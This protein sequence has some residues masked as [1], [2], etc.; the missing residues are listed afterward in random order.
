MNAVS[1]TC[2]ASAVSNPVMI[3]EVKVEDTISSISQGIRCLNKS[4]TEARV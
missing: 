4:Q 1:A 3:M 2:A